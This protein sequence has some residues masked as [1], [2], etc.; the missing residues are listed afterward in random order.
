[1]T[2]IEGLGSSSS[3]RFLTAS[4]ECPLD[5]FVTIAMDPLS[6]VLVGL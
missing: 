3:T 4:V 6:G 2:E 1:M 5:E